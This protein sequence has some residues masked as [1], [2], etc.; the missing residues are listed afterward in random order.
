MPAGHWSWSGREREYDNAGVTYWPF[1]VSVASAERRP[2][3]NW[4]IIMQLEEVVNCNCVE[5]L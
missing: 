4:L 5:A 2:T 1:S 3:A